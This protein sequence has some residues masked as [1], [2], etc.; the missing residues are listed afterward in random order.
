[1]K[2]S[3][4]LKKHIKMAFYD[5][6]RGYMQGQTRALMNCYKQK[7]KGKMGPQEAWCECIKEYQD[8]DNKDEWMLNYTSAKDND[9]NTSLSAKTPAAQKI[10]NK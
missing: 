8:T 2:T 4:N 6:A 10:I 3:F 1:M 5:G 9:K 7:C